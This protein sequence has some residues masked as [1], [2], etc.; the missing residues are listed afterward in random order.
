MI[1][2][3]NKSSRLKKYQYPGDSVHYITTE[4]LFK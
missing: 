4:K 2:K 3:N 1:P